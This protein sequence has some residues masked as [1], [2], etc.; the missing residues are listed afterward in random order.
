VGISVSC[1]AKINLTLEIQHR[2]PDGYHELKSV[3]QSV[4]LHDV[5][6]MER[7]PAGTRLSVEPGSGWKGEFDRSS[8]PCNSRNLAWQAAELF[9]AHAGIRSG[10]KIRLVKNIPVAAGLAGGSA[11]A[12]GVLVG[13]NELFGPVMDRAGLARLGRQLGADVPFCLIGGT[14]LASGIGDVL[15]PVPVYW[16]E[17]FMILSPYL[18]VS[19]PAAYRAY[20]C[21]H[22]SENHVP[23]TQWKDMVQA[24]ASDPDQV[25]GLLVN[26]FE[27][28]VFGIHPS[29]R[30]LKRVTQKLLGNAL[31]SG[32]GPTVFGIIQ[33]KKLPEVELRRRIRK[34]GFCGRCWIV[35]P[36]ESGVV[37]ERVD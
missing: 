26:D 19:T 30:Q 24:L 33:E 12:A 34:Q 18:K 13:M 11:D 36:A 9:R 5:I 27:R 1:C 6:Y 35:P 16:P 7:I 15:E 28:V 29:L 22:R 4:G 37:V 23:G 17:G 2:R 20:D 31:L 25:P 32:S 3:M 10:V 8:V 14:A 21:M